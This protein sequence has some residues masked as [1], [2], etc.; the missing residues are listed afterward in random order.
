MAHDVPS[1]VVSPAESSAVAV[2]LEDR[3]ALTA[4]DRSITRAISIS[5]L[6]QVQVKGIRSELKQRHYSIGISYE[7]G[8]V[9]QML[10]VHC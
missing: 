1:T 5:P 8:H 6:S 10:T 9:I 7:E 2:V 3:Y 4:R